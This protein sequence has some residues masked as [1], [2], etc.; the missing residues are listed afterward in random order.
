VTRRGI[1]LLTTPRST[2]G[3]TILGIG[4]VA[5]SALLAATPAGPTFPSLVVDQGKVLKLE[6]L[7]GR[8][9][10]VN[11]WAS[12]CV[13]CRAELASLEKLAASRS[14]QVIV[15]AASVDSD[16]RLGRTAMGSKYPHL[17]LVF[18]SLAA[19]QDYGALGMPYSVV[20]NKNGREVK[21]VTRAIDWAG[22]EAARIIAQAN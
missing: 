1:V 21:R 7:R 19:V 22:P 13:P 8:T 5:S 2:L 11:F 3:L 12:W 6:S 4:A 9:V 18:A 17:R 10:V 14:G 15:I 16:R 20:F